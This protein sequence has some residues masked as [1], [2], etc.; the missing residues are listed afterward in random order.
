MILRA[1]QGPLTSPSTD[2]LPG[3]GGQLAQASPWHLC[4]CREA[5]L[6]LLGL[7]FCVGGEGQ[8]KAVL[9]ISSYCFFTHE[10]SD[11]REESVFLT[12]PWQVR[13]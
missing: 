11:G 6:L 9:H 1:E 8:G 3:G 12:P 4:S 2:V 5:V 7:D 10:V 13:Q